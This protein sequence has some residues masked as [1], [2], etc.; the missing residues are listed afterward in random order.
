M[1]GRSAMT[2]GPGVSAF[3]VSANSRPP[4]YP[5]A[6]PS[7]QEIQAAVD[8]YVTAIQDRDRSA[9]IDLFTDDAVAW[10]PY[11][12]SRFQGRDGVGEWW[13]VIIAPVAKTAFDIHD[14]HICG[15]R[16][17]MVWTITASLDGESEVQLSGVDVFTVTDDS[18]ISSLSAY[19][20]PSRLTP[21]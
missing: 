7:S 16:G 9:F 18:K 15:D 3:C 1:G 21:V 4:L 17:V 13:D 10:D 5:Q 2:I 19:W 14:L 20:D 8:A 12:D 6:M 11:P